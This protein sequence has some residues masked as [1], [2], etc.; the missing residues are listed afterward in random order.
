MNLEIEFKANDV[1]FP[2]VDDDLITNKNGCSKVKL[3]IS[4]KSLAS[5]NIDLN[6]KKLDKSGLSLISCRSTTTIITSSR[7]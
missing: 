6:C 4:Y 5:V 2:E 7:C 3:S 1:I